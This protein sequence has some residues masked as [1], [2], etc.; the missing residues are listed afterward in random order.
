MVLLTVVM[1]IIVQML[2]S[3][4][5]V[6]RNIKI[7]RELESS[8]AIVMENMLRE[9]R[10]ASSVVVGESSLG[11]NPGTLTIS[12]VDESL[13]SYKMAFDVSSG[14]LRISK[15]E[16]TPTALTSSSGVVSYLLFTRVAT[17]TSEGVKVELEMSGTIGSVSRSERFYGF[18][19]LR[20]S[21]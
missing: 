16:G 19:V 20:G 11:V 17:S 5:G 3:M 1:V 7:T 9:I 14:V 18:S 4:G 15:D 10:N 6:Y 8:G 12:G 13:N 2:I 21:Y